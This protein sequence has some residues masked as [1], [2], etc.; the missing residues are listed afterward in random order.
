MKV[1][2]TNTGRKYTKLLNVLRGT[3]KLAL[4]FSGGLDSSFLAVAALE[5]LGNN[6]VLAITAL[7]PLFPKSQEIEA[8]ALAKKMKLC[9]HTFR[10]APLA[11]SGFSKNR[12]D[13]CYLCKRELF[14]RMRQIA[15]KKGFALLADGTNADDVYDFRPGMK[16]AAEQGVA[17][18]LKDAG[19]T[20]E[21]IRRLASLMNLSFAQK[22]S[23]A[24]LASRIPY[25]EQITPK[26]LQQVDAIEMAL[27]KMGFMQVRARHHGSVV[28]IEVEER[29]IAL[30]AGRYRNRIQEEGRSVGF[31]HTSIDLKGY[32]QGS[33]NE[34]IFHF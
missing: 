5:A 25:G 2:Q 17:H 14:W 7:S 23:S 28:R 6:N 31:L 19:L 21:E 26:K 32:R 9:Q 15:E 34:K 10:L 18:P 1:R 12:R 33:L 13:R 29:M 22:P 27:Q 30:A 4:A 3:R 11:I 20:K 16:A 24:C 8:A